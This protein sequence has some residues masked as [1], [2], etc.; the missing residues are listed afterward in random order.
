MVN[1]KLFDLNRARIIFH[2]FVFVFSTA[3][4]TFADSTQFDLPLLGFSQVVSNTFNQPTVITHAGDSSG[5]LFVVEQSGR[6]WIIQS[7][8]VL[9]QPFLDISDR[10]LSGDFGSEQGLLG[11]TFSPRF[12]TN[13]HFYVDYIRKPDGATVVSRFSL[14]TN[15]NIAN[16]NSEQILKVI[17]QPYDNHN[18]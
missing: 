1:R 10:I 11:L 7:N 3:I 17:A 16:V 5:R 15:S 6:I 8:N 12:A 13:S 2:L 4:S 18:G 14:T 9:T